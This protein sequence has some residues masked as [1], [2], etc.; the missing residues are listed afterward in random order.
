MI[1]T[2]LHG[3]NARCKFSKDLAYDY[4]FYKHDWKIVSEPGAT[5]QNTDLQYQEEKK[6]NDHTETEYTADNDHETEDKVF[7]K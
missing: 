2:D 6:S 3:I 5:Q 7:K 1:G 4:M